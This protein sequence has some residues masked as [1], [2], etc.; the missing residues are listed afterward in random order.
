M[1]S[2]RLHNF[3]WFLK[4]HISGQTQTRI[5]TSEEMRAVIPV[6]IVSCSCGFFIQIGI[7]LQ[8][9]LDAQIQFRIQTKNTAAVGN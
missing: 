6:R 3:S 1:A 9:L 2:A 7:R 4:I 5:A 8:H